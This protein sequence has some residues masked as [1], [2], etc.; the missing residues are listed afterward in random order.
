MKA[1]TIVFE[2]STD[3]SSGVD[4]E[5]FSTYEKAVARFN[6]IIEDEQNPDISW[7]SDA[8]NE[9]GDLSEDY[10]L[11][12][13]EQFTDNKEHELWWDIKCQHNWYLHDFLELRILEV[14]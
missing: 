5:V 8:W 13:N 3:D 14:K 1:Y 10:E 4:V 9:N 6:E 7:V 2:W 12:C 11:N